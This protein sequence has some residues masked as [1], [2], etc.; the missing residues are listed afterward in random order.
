[1]IQRDLH[2]KRLFR[3]I[4]YSMFVFFVLLLISVGLS[5]KIYQMM[6]SKYAV[7]REIRLAKEEELEIVLAKKNKLEQNLNFLASP[8]GIEKELRSKFDV[9]REGESV[10]IVINSEAEEEIE[11]EQPKAMQRFWT[12]VKSLFE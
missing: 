11:E 2:K 8:L 7:S 12:S 5:V 3:K 9:S 10:V 4:L 6:S 1:M